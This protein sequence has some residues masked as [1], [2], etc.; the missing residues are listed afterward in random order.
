VEWNPNWATD[1]EFK[2]F[3]IKRKG[4]IIGRGQN[5][6]YQI[7]SALN[8]FH[9]IKIGC[10][11]AY[12]SCKIDILIW[13]DPA[14]FEKNWHEIKEL[15]CLKFALNPV[16]YD[17]HGITDIRGIKAN[18]PG[19]CSLNIDSGFYP[20]NLSGYV[21]LN[22]ALIIGL[23]PIWLYGFCP[24]TDIVR[25]RSESFKMLADW[26]NKNRRQIYIAD[27]ESYLRKFFEYKKIPLRANKRKLKKET[28]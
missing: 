1:K 3:F 28:N 25:Q 16:H 5:D 26:A 7:Q 13:M 24:N 11:R 9:G 14:F 12:V 4:L 18:H 19:R 22:L 21:A 2:D 6:D 8:R 23:N 10:N 15:D 17:H 27:E 20:C